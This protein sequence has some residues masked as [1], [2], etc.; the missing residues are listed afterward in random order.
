VKAI[1]PVCPHCHS[2]KVDPKL[3]TWVC[4]SCG[5]ATY[6][7]KW[8]HC[9]FVL[10]PAPTVDEV[11]PNVAVAMAAAGSIMF[12]SMRPEEVEAAG[13]QAIGMLLAGVP[14][15]TIKRRGAI[16]DTC[17]YPATETR[18]GGVAFCDTCAALHDD[19]LLNNEGEGNV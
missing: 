14:E 16:C 13:A 1:V 12:D 3:N 11:T 8:T 17:E 2:S 18:D 9:G 4:R 10:P 7:V 19:D 6:H 15:V 5:R